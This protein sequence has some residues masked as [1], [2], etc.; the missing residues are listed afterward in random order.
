MSVA[1]NRK[2][3]TISKTLFVVVRKFFFFPSLNKKIFF[4]GNYH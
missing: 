4:P 2:Q 3:L 1:K